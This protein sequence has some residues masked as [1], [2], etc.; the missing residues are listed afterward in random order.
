MSPLVGILRKL[1]D[2]RLRAVSTVVIPVDKRV[3]KVEW[4]YRTTLSVRTLRYH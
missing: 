1:K 2:L 3:R 4:T